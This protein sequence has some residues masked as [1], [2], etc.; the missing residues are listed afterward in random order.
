[1]PMS[2]SKVSLVNTLWVAMV[3]GAAVAIALVTVLLWHFY[4]FGRAF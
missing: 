2:K 3:F 4:S 1:M